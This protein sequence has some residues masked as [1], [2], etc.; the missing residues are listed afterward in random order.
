MFVVGCSLCCCLALSTQAVDFPA[1]YNT[2]K[3]TVPFTSPEEA[4]KKMTLPPG[5]QVT[6]FAAEPDIRQPIHL[7]TDT[8]GRVWVAECYSY[9]ENKVNFAADQRDRI[10]ILEDTDGDGR[11][12]KRTVFWDKASKLTSVE[13]GF[14]GVWALCAPHLLF[15]PDKNG[16]DV[17]DGEP[18]VLLDGWDDDTVRHNI[19]NGLKWGPDGWL[20]GRHGIQATSSVGRLG[21]PDSARTKLNCAIWRFHPTRHVFEVVCHGGTNSWGHDWDEHGQLFFINTVIGHFWHAIPGAY[22]KR[23]YGEHLRPHLYELI[24][25]HADHLHWD[26]KDTWNDIRKGVTDTTSAAGGGHAHSGFMI[27]LGDNWPDQYRGTAFTINLHGL[28]LN[29]DRIERRGSGYVSKHNPDFLFAN[30]PWFRGVELIYGPDGGVFVADWADLDECHENDGIHRTSGRIYKITHERGTGVNPD[31]PVGGP[32][33]SPAQDLATM[34]D[35]DLVKFQLHKNDWHARQARHVLHQR[36]A[37]GRNVTP[38]HAPLKQMFTDQSVTSHKL[39]ALWTLHVTGELDAQWLRQQLG[40]AD[41]HVRAWAVQLLPAYLSPQDHDGETLPAMA[42]R[43][44]S[45]LVRLQLASVLPQLDLP[46]RLGVAQALLA[47]AHDADDHNLPLVLWYGLEETVAKS[48]LTARTMTQY[49]Q[50]PLIRQFI[51]RRLAEDWTGQLSHID[52]IVDW[53]AKVYGNIV[54]TYEIDV[55]EGMASGL[56]GVR[57]AEAPRSW[58]AFVRKCA[59]IPDERIQTLIRELSVVFGDGRAL[60]EVRRIAFDPKADGSQRGPALQALID[61]RPDDLLKVLQNLISDRVVAGVAVRG[62]ALFDEPRNANLILA[63]RH[64]W[65]PD[66]QRAAIDTLAAR[67]SYAKV[68][69]EAVADGRIARSEVT[70]AHARQMRSFGDETLTALLA[71][72]WGDVRGTAEEKEQLMAQHRAALTPAALQQA[73]LAKGRELYIV[74]CASCHALFGQGGIIG[75]DL[76]GGDRRNLNYLLENIVD[77]NAMVPADFK[78]SVVTLKDGRVLNGVVGARTGRTLTLQTPTEKLTLERAEVEKIEDSTLSLMPEGLLEAM[79]AGQV[80]DLIAYLQS[81]QQVP[82]PASR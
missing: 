8:R 59:Q 35:A 1:P 13:V 80:R 23:M 24:D 3:E 26:T 14:G 64:R 2:Q 67:P 19:V 60:D 45:P 51:V 62:L 69:L 47:N 32:P 31:K 70:A 22:Y 33:V 79:T 55:L 28:R 77:P 50:I 15:I 4:V 5:F 75:P 20:Y 29:N 66:A 21:T 72:V 82:L 81:P 44:T 46:V 34:S 12:D 65:L 36:A 30:D 56:R 78:M 61:A 38:I 11:H 49:S 25:Q 27:Y 42:R 68:L 53:G 40:H 41:E 74:A 43:E 9:A 7:T 16:D 71:K 63:Q 54:A 76:T 17:P 10:V 57:K 37:A 48:P 73:D 58:S 6:V 52:S 39:R 18:I